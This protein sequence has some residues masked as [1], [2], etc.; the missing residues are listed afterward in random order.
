ML[1]VGQL[2]NSLVAHYLFR[3]QFTNFKKKT[4]H[5]LSLSPLGEVSLQYLGSA[6]TEDLVHT[7][8]YILDENVPPMQ[9]SQTL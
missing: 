8:F 7:V 2:D 3:N 9:T 4:F 5:G 6:S 1:S